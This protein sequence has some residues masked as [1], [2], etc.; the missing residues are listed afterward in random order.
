MVKRI[1]EAQGNVQGMNLMEAKMTFIKAWQSL[2]EYGLT[3]FIIKMKGSKKEVI[4]FFLSVLAQFSVLFLH[5]T[6]T[7]VRERTSSILKIDL[8]PNGYLRF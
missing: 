1:L 3:Y 6:M 7:E 4:E 8:L 5:S 2:P